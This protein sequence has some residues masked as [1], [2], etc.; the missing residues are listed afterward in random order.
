MTRTWN[1]VAVGTVRIEP[2]RLALIA[3]P[4]VL[5]D[6]GMAEE[7]AREVKRI[8]S[9]LKIPF[10][11]KASYAK[12]NRSAADSYRGPGAGDGLRELA[13]IRETVGVPV[14]SDVHEASEVA[15]AAEIL[16]LIQ[17]PAFLCR[18]TALIEAAART[19][20]P[21]HLK[22]GQF[23]DPGSME[24]AVEKARA[25]GAKGIV[26]TERGTMFGYGDLVVDFRGI[27]IM[28]RFQCPVFFDA[29]HSVQRPGGAETGGQ[30][31][32]IPVLGRAAVAAG[33]DGIFIE[34][35]PDPPRARSD[36]ESQ[37]PL[38][39]LKALL[40]SWVKIRQSV[41]DERLVGARP[42]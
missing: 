29:T 13:R 25:A 23:L 2:G 38:S 32:F 8:A 16:D 12:A 7:V 9:E 14:T 28:K 40:Q 1:A 11:F 26:V 20:K 19:G 39:E 34:T 31:E 22:K 35:H 33:V 42:A 37:W 21:V 18:Q 15:E 6:A 4:C 27:E 5:E 3:G 36:R 17:V 30:R 24:R 10:V 41:A